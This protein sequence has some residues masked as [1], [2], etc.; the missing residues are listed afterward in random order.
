MVSELNNPSGYGTTKNR[1]TAGVTTTGTKRYGEDLDHVK[2]DGRTV[3]VKPKP[4]MVKR[5]DKKDGVLDDLGMEQSSNA[6]VAVM[7]S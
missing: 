7:K 6:D 2:I 4:L 1:R 5:S 3:N